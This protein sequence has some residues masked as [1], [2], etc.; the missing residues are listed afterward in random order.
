[1]KAKNLFEKITFVYGFIGSNALILDSKYCLY[2]S[3]L[4]LFS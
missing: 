4:W 2:L 1:M 3:L